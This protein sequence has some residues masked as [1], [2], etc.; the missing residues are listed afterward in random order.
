MKTK[1][2]IVSLKNDFF[3]FS[4]E[5]EVEVDYSDSE[6]IETI[7]IPERIPAKY[8]TELKQQAIE[9]FRVSILTD[10]MESIDYQF[11]Q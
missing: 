11:N 4:H 2:I 3:P 5:V 8:H 9:Q 6:T 1:Y 10:K 7:L